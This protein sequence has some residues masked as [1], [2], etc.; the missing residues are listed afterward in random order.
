MRG[1]SNL[2]GR[3]LDIWMHRGKYMIVQVLGGDGLYVVFSGLV[4]IGLAKAGCA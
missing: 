4:G 1:S 2:T 3:K